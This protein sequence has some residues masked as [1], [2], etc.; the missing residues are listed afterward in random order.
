MRVNKAAIVGLGATD[1][2]KESGRT[3][4]HLAVEAILSALSDAGLPPSDVD[5]LV[6]YDHDDTEVIDIARSIGADDLRFF[7]RSH[8][9]GGG[10]CTTVQLAAMAVQLGVANVVVAYRS[11]NGKSSGFARAPKPGTPGRFDSP[12]ASWY[13][14]FGLRLPATKV[15]LI[16]RR[17]MHQ[18]G[19][20]SE[21]FGRVA[22]TSRRHAATN[23]AA[24]FYER[25]ITLDDHQRS[26]MVSDPLRL[27]DCCMESDGAVAVIVTSAER[28]N[29]LRMPPVIVGAAASGSRQGQHSITTYYRDDIAGVPEVTVVAAQLWQ[30]SGLTP[31]DINI[32]VMYDHFTP[33]VLMQLEALGVCGLGEAPSFVEDGHIE[34]DGQLPV[35]PHGGQLGE[36]YIHGMNGIA[37]AIRQVRGTAVN[38][39][40]GTECAL[41]TSGTTT[42]TS[43]LILQKER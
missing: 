24:W 7:P 15:A 31:D 13:A 42:P 17:Y 4:T 43:G 36:A 33:T 2:S 39:V 25:P 14:P 32:A 22:V 34:L 40:T 6:T 37:E 38:Q 20:T 1:F 23:P 27:L 3:E 28:A 10:A 8:F 21:D 19:A 30:Q 26:R 18:Y 12:A 16:A 11:L 9:G 41:V 5:G 29:D 35:N